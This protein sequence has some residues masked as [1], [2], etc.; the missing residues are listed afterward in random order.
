MQKIKEILIA[1]GNKGKIKEISDLLKEVGIKAVSAAQFNLKEPEED[2]ISF[3]ENS[4]IKARFYANKTGITSLADDSG[5]CIKALDNNPGIHS[6]RWAIDENSG[7]KDFD[8]AFK[9]IETALIEK[10]ITDNNKNHAAYFICNLSLFNPKEDKIIS[11]EG[12]VDGNI[13]FPAKGGNG[14]GYD[15]IFTATGMN[16]TFGEIKSEE[17]DLISHRTKAFLQLKHYLSDF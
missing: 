3:E 8:L 15:P 10:N 9:R 5:L 1:S 2:G 4:Q 12:R 7:E 17:K 14:F 13:S 6:A 16:K 11:F